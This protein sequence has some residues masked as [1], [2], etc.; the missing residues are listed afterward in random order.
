[1]TDGIIG[2]KILYVRTH[3]H[4][5]TLSNRHVMQHPTSNT[6][7]YIRVHAYATSRLTVWRRVRSPL[8]VGAPW[9]I[10]RRSWH[11]CRWD[12]RPRTQ[13]TDLC[14]IKHR[15]LFKSILEH[16]TTK[17]LALKLLFDPSTGIYRPHYVH[18]TSTIFAHLTQMNG[19]LYRSDIIKQKLRFHM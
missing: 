3:A 15:D 18:V 8:Y 16:C 17:L 6:H 11:R 13:T 12:N 4:T 14:N 10:S 2:Y 1:M 5:H 7:I 9:C 19:A